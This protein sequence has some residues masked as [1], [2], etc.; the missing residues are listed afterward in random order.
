[1]VSYLQELVM[2][3]LRQVAMAIVAHPDDIE[4]GLAGTMLLLGQAGYELHYMNVANG[5]C[6]TATHTRADIVRLRTGEAKQAAKTLGAVFHPPLVDD[7]DIFYTKPL[8]SRVTAVLRKVN[9]TILLV[10]S[11]IDYMEDHMIAGRL[12]VTGAFCRG[13]RNFPTSPRTKPVAGEVTVYHAMPAS[14][15]D[16]MRKRVLPE[17]YVDITSVLARKREALAQHK[18]QKEW[19]DVSQGMDAYLITMEQQAAEVGKL[20]GKFRF[21]EGLRRHSHLGFCEEDTDPLAEALGKHVLINKQYRRWLEEPAGL[22][23]QKKARTS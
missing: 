6:G 22:N 14:L 1:M 2:A 15:R 7:L 10:P 12:A 16:P 4:F 5:S 21:A 11:P 3:A 8:L 23:K 19:L 20:S 18:S 17:Y 13:M 9:P